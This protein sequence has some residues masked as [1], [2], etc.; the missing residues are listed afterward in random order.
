MRNEPLDKQKFPSLALSILTSREE[1]PIGVI[2]YLSDWYKI[3]P[4]LHPD[5]PLYKLMNKLAAEQHTMLLS[6]TGNELFSV[7]PKDDHEGTFIRY[8]DELC[9]E[10]DLFIQEYA[11]KR[12]LVRVH[13][14]TGTFQFIQQLN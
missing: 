11:D 10:D 1:L 6:G 7:R 13:P 12:A 5:S 4:S 9:V 3:K 2:I 8:K 14:K